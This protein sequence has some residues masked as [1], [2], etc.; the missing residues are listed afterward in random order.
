[1]AKLTKIAI[2][3]IIVAVVAVAGVVGFLLWPREV[4]DLSYNFKPGE[5]YVYEAIQT[6]EIAGQKIDTKTKLKTDVLRVKANEFTVR[7]DMIIQT[8]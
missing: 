7:C 2:I 3:G 6:R 5:T 8:S 4:Y 1:M